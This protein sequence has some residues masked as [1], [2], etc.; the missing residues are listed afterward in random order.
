MVRCI[1]CDVFHVRQFCR[2]FYC[3]AW[4]NTVEFNHFPCPDNKMYDDGFSMIW[5]HY[6]LSMFGIRVLI[7]PSRL[8][9]SHKAYE[10]DTIKIIAAFFLICY[11]LHNLI[12]LNSI[13]CHVLT[14]RR[15]MM[16]C[17]LIDS[18]INWLWVMCIFW[19]GYLDSL[20]LIFHMR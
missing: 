19:Y 15:T 8:L 12:R 16:P 2:F 9:H 4:S 5:F 6:Q 18:T 17:S 7:A 10:L 20:I 13:V 3:L 1:T 11:C 14:T